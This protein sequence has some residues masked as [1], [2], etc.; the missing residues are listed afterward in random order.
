MKKILV[1]DDDVMLL[2][3]VKQTLASRFL[4]LTAE[5]GKEAQARLLSSQ[6]IVVVCLRYCCRLPRFCARS[7]IALLQ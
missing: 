5:K 7:Q 4:V 6:D 3:A 1:I 2:N